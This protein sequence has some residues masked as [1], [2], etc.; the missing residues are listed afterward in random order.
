MARTPDQE[1]FRL[2]ISITDQRMALLEGRALVAEYTVSTALKRPSEAFN[3]DGTPRGLHVVSEK[4]GDGQPVG[5]IFKGRQPT[6]VISELNPDGVPPVVTRL[7][8]LRGLEATNRTSYE[9]LIYLHGSPHEKLL[10]QPASGGCIR[11]SSEDVIEL[12]RKIGVGTSI[13]ILEEPLR[14]AIAITLDHE[15][16]FEERRHRALTDLIGGKTDARA[17]H[18]MCVGHMYGTYGVPQN[19]R[20][21]QSWCEMSADSGGTA[22]ITALAEIHERGT[23]GP[24]NLPKARS[25]FEKAAAMG[26]PRAMTKA[27]VMQRHGI[28]GPQD[29]VGAKHNGDR[30]AAL[31]A[32]KPELHIGDAVNT[33]SNPSP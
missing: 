15:Q 23:L 5:T 14:S 11:M 12:F 6:G 20:A 28:G 30:L 27:A 26:D 31:K 21:A 9:R 32:E 10:G 24:A 16:Q 19:Y 18:E 3:S 33:T 29:L 1:R 2:V 22:A 4:I 17:L 8:R 13:T 25:L 7:F